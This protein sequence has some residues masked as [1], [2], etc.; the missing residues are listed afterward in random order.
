MRLQNMK[1]IEPQQKYRLGTISNKNYLPATIYPSR[2]TH[3]PNIAGRVDP[4]ELTR[5]D[6]TRGQVDPDSSRVADLSS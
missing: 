2:D 5:A 1:Q 6:L 3:T 4:A